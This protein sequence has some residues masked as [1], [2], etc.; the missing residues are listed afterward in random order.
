MKP[1]MNNNS[2]DILIAEDSRTQADKLGFLL[3]E[4]GFKVTIAANGKQALLAAKAQKPD[5][6]ISDIVMPEMDGYELCKAIK[7]DEKLQDIPV[8]LVTTLSDSQD[9]IR[10][11][12]CGA[13]N[14]IRKPY[15]ERYLLS[16]INY[17]LMN[18]DMRKE[19]KMQ[20]GVQ[21]N[22][23]GKKYFINS[24]RQQILDLLIS[25][26]EQ[27]VHINN[28]LVVALAVPFG[29]IETKQ[30]GRAS[31]QVTANAVERMPG[32]GLG[33]FPQLGGLGRSQLSISARTAREGHHFFS[34]NRP[35]GQRKILRRGGHNHRYRHQTTNKG[36]SKHSQ[37]VR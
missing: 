17:L 32:L 27:A 18:L 16:R 24:E 15:D 28:E 13:D 12:E 30:K 10:G 20:L 8:I 7:S 14:F 6:I 4:N 37:P 34:R 9:V 31:G 22:L 2:I 29:L 5:L 11:L 25:T 1:E 26:Y 23:G 19:N 36:R 35:E 21:I 33:L 3:E